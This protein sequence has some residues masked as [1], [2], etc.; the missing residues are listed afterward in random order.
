MNKKIFLLLSILLIAGCSSDFGNEIDN[1]SQDQAELGV[2]KN[3]KKQN[4]K[5]ELNNMNINKNNQNQNKEEKEVQKE[6]LIDL[7]SEYQYAILKTNFG[8]IQLSFYGADSPNT[9]NNFL[10]LAKED[11]YDGTKFHR[12]INDFMIQGGDPNSKDDDWSND[13]AG[14]PGYSFE[15]EFNEHK[16]VRGSLAMANSGPNTNGSQFFIVTAEATPWLDGRH[17]N[18]GYVL[19]GMDI[20]DKIE[21]VE[22]NNRDHPIDDVIIEDVELVK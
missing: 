17:T 8:D 10:K 16:L 6:E 2:E 22:K 5:K 15:D 3:I 19:V 20:V 18:F 21:A 4:Q 1:S 13:G 14:G 11:F 9:V 7:A 12:V